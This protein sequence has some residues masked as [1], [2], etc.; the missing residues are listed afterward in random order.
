MTDE[1]NEKAPETN[2]PP[3]RNGTANPAARRVGGIFIGCLL[4]V[5]LI[6]IIANLVFAIIGL[7]TGYLYLPSAR[8]G[9]A[10][11]LYGVWAR[12]VSVIVLLFYGGIAFLIFRWSRKQRHPKILGD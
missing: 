2:L 12:V 5:F 9:E 4:L 11:E 10:I 3:L 6:W 1:P 8:G 7:I